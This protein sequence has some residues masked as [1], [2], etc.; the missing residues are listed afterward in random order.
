MTIPL[1]VCF[2][3]SRLRPNPAALRGAYQTLFLP[4][5]AITQFTCYPLYRRRPKILIMDG[6]I[7]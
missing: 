7:P 3:R 5:G 4:D 2:E 1:P 6:A